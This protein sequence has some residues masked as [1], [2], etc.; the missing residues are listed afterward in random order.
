M[1]IQIPTRKNFLP[2]LLVCVFSAIGYA[3]FAT[4]PQ[5]SRIEASPQIPAVEVANIVLKNHSVSATVQGRIVAPNKP[6]DLKS[7]TSGKIVSTHPNFIV[8]GTIAAGEPVLQIDQ[9]DYLIAL[10]NAQA[11]LIMAQAALAIEQGQKRLAEREFALNTVQYT[12]DGQNKALALR[13]PQIK[14]AQ[15]EVTLAKNQLNLAQLALQ[16]T[17]LSFPFKVRVLSVSAGLGEYVS[18]QNLLAT[19]S[20]ADQQWLELSIPQIYLAQIRARTADAIGSSVYFK[21]GNT[22][23][24]AEV[25][26]IKAELNSQSRMSGLI[27]QV[28]GDL[29]NQTS[30]PHSLIIGTHVSAS[31]DLGIVENALALPKQLL[32]DPITDICIG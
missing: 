30:N 1:S 18:Q 8:G 23:Y 3:I 9:T 29:S 13:E 2:L 28:V 4:A 7:Q 19:L 21:V 15:A 32:R 17:S 12:F 16:R 26:S 20:R 5:S 25:I 24:T 14:Q 6:L 11:K 27:A 10:E 22:E 31:I